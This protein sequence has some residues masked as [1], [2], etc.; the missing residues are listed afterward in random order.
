MPDKTTVMLSN[1]SIYK[2]IVDSHYNHYLELN[3]E[4]DE[5]KK[6]TSDANVAEM[7]GELYNLESA[8][9]CDAA[10]ILVFAQMTIEAFCNVYLLQHF[11]KTQIKDKSF[12]DKLKL[13]II[14]IMGEEGKTIT[15]ADAPNYYG[16]D[17]PGIITIRKKFVHRYPISFD[18]SLTSEDEFKKDSANGVQEIE[19]GYLRRVK[20]ADVDNAATAYQRLLDKL[21][22]SGAD[23]DKFRFQYE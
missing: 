4:Y 17:I 14:T 8:M 19:A 9:D 1:I 11:S 18:L 3:T 22:A 2:K 23:F 13:S 21:K 6:K 20:R 5:M 16:A 15:E 7:A 12:I 10:V